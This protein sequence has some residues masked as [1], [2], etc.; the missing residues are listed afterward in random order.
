VEHNSELNATHVAVLRVKAD[1][2]SSSKAQAR[3]VKHL[4]WMVDAQ[5]KK[6]LKH[7]IDIPK[8]C[9]KVKQLALEETH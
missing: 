3:E 2:L 4:S 8:V 6:K 9:V 1:L 5:L 7:E